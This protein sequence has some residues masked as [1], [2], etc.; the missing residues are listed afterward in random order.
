[1]VFILGLFGK[2]LWCFLLP[3]VFCGP[4]EL[5]G[6]NDSFFFFLYSSL[7]SKLLTLL[8]GRIKLFFCTISNMTM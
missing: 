4:L 8:R 2:E 7:L 3:F 1:M 5:S 6:W